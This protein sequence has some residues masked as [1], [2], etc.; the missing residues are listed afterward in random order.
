V[1]TR[2]RSG[3]GRWV[4]HP[5]LAPLLASRGAA[6]DSTG[7]W[8]AAACTG[9]QGASKDDPDYVRALL[10]YGA[11][12][13]DRRSGYLKAQPACG[14]SRR[15]PCTRRQEPLPAK[16]RGA[17]RSGSRP[18]RSRQPRPDPAGLAGTSGADGSAGRSP[19]AARR[20]SDVVAS[21]S[22]TVRC[23]NCGGQRQPTERVPLSDM[24]FRKPKQV[25]CPR[26]AAADRA[27]SSRDCADR[28]RAR[29]RAGT[30]FRL[31]MGFRSADRDPG[32]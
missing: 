11:R 1:R 12:A 28:V 18:R 8:I 25:P 4:L 31:A 20:R 29:T 26:R 6:I 10:R 7:A 15:R 17:P 21:L 19:S 9:N 23:A 2:A 5:E 16:L 14:H 27:R 30:R 32:K 22:S 3:T 13:A 24:L